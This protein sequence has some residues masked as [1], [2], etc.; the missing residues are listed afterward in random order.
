MVLESTADLV[1]RDE[2]GPTTS[3]SSSVVELVTRVLL[4]LRNNEVDLEGPGTGTLESRE[5][6][7]LVT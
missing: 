7:A 1:P 4:P 2:L 5:V 3:T 6:P